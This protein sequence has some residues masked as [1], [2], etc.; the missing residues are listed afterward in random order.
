MERFRS[1]HVLMPVLSDIKATDICQY[2]SPEGIHKFVGGIYHV[3]DKAGLC[4]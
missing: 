1:Y 4:R 2:I 3:Y